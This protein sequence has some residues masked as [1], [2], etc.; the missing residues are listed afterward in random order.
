LGINLLLSARD[1]QANL[2]RL[3]ALPP[4]DRDLG[5]LMRDAQAS[6]RPFEADLAAAQA[7]LNA[8]LADPADASPPP[9]PISAAILNGARKYTKVD[10]PILA[11]FESPPFLPDSTPPEVRAAENDQFAAQAKAFEAGLPS[12]HVVRLANARHAIWQTNE[13]DVLR[14]MSAFMAKLK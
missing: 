7:A 14:E 11:F 5:P 9:Q 8:E 10:V 2:D 6:L 3:K 12:A 13:A 4:Q 1:V